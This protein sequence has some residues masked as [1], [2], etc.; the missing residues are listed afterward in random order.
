MSVTTINPT[1]LVTLEELSI[2]TILVVT[3]V[4]FL[5]LV[6]LGVLKSHK[7]KEENERLSK[8]TLSSVD[9]NKKYEDFRQ[10]H[11]YE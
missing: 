5:I 8:S 1:A 2:V 11:L 7:L 10:G 6:I 9:D 3:S 4:F